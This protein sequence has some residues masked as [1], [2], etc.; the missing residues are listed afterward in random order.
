MKADICLSVFL[1]DEVKTGKCSLLLTFIF[2]MSRR[3]I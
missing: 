3:E 2:M 1:R